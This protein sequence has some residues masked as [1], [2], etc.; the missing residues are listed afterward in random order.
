MTDRELIYTACEESRELD[1]MTS[2]DIQGLP[3]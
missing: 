3:L 2:L 1:T